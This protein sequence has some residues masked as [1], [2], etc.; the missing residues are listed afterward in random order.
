MGTNAKL[1]RAIVVLGAALTAGGC[2]EDTCTTCVPDAVA[3][4]DAATTDAPR[5]APVDAMVDA[6]LIL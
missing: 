1:F 3:Q 4:V 2:E 5:D 6:I